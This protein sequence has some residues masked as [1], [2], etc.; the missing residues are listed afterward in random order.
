MRDLQ[1]IG[2]DAALTRLWPSLLGRCTGTTAVDLALRDAFRKMRGIVAGRKLPD[3][4][5]DLD[6]APG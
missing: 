1:M 6:V 4:A 3:L 5:C 2:F